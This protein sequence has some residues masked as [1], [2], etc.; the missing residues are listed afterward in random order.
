[1][2]PYIILF[3]LTILSAATTKAQLN[4]LDSGDVAPDFT[5][6]DALGNSYT[7]SQI[8]DS[9]KYVLIDFFGYWCGSCR[10]KAPIVQSFYNKYGCNEFDVFVIG[11]ECDGNNAQ[12]YT[13]DTLVNLPEPHYPS[14]SGVEG[15]GSLIKS[16][17]GVASFPTLVAI[18]PDRKVINENIFPS[19]NA[20]NLFSGFQTNSI[21]VNIC[22]S[23]S[24]TTIPSLEFNIS[25]NPA[26][27]IL[28]IQNTSAH[29]SR[30]RIVDISGM[31]ALQGELSSSTINIESLRNGIY[32][33]LVDREKP[34]KLIVIN[35]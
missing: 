7:L 20:F 34:L 33:I 1:M 16:T 2:K 5:V 10:T 25:P 19:N 32:W 11:I 13:F 17:Y 24:I 6:I 29:A 30:Y 9:G 12:L 22:L 21:S 23:N 26:S 28:N 35:P 31:T 8:T 18:G 4:N 15:G 3:F 27:K 14:V